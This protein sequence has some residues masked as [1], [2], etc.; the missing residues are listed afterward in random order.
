MTFFVGNYSA[1]RD[2]VRWRLPVVGVPQNELTIL[3]S[4]FRS[5]TDGRYTSEIEAGLLRQGWESVRFRRT[6]TA[7]ELIESSRNRSISEQET[8]ANLFQRHGG[9]VLITGEVGAVDRVVRLRIFDKGGNN[10]VSVDLDLQVE[11]LNILV[12][13]IEGAVWQGLVHAGAHR[14]GESDNEFLR[15]VFPIES[16][17]KELVDKASKGTLVEDAKDKKRRLSIRIGHVLGD[18][19]RLISAR[20]DI[21]SKLSKEGSFQTDDERITAMGSVA[22]LLRTEGLILGDAQLLDLSFVRSREVRK[23]LE[24][25]DDFLYPDNLK[26]NPGYKEMMEIESVVALACRDQKRISE[27]LE[28]YER[29]AGCSTDTMDINCPAWSTRAIFAL[30]YG[31]FAWSSSN[32]SHLQAT[33]Y[34]IDYWTRVIGYGGRFRHW[35]DPMTHTDRLLRARLGIN[36]DAHVYLS[37]SGRPLPDSVPNE[38][39]C[40][41][42]IKLLVLPSAPNG[43]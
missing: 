12:P 9:D 32:V 37:T 14:F 2:W 23:L 28:L 19:S 4:Q 29:V 15:R 25:P 11:W 21:E 18:V 42:L 17:V 27:L 33:A 16:K 22:D 10:P 26:V 36:S 34:V 24:V 43:R 1:V 7:E 39:A 40:P 6:L 5:D 8:V 41:N 38:N 30:R 20:Q 13:Y 3:I 31:H 35:L